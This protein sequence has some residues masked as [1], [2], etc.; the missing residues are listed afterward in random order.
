MA[1]FIDDQ[2]SED[3]ESAWNALCKTTDGRNYL[4]VSASFIVS[5]LVRS[6]TKSV[7]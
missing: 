4:Q 7:R 1:D 2:T 5:A 6:G 3:E